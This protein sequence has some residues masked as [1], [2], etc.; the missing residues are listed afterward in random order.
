M[1]DISDRLG[2]P[3]VIIPT[4]SM[5]ILGA[6]ATETPEGTKLVLAS[7]F[8]PSFV[9]YGVQFNEGGKPTVTLERV[10]SNEAS[11]D[12]DGG[13]PKT[14][15][16]ETAPG[17]SAPRAGTGQMSRDRKTLFYLQNGGREIGKYDVTNGT[18]LP[19]LG[20]LQE[21]GEDFLMTSPG[22]LTTIEDYTDC[23]LREYSFTDGLN[24]QLSRELPLGASMIYGLCRVNGKTLVVAPSASNASEEPGVY[25]V[26]YNS[27]SQ[28]SLLVKV[29]E[30]SLL[31]PTTRALTPVHQDHKLKGFF[32]ATY[33]FR[34]NT[35]SLGT[36][37]QLLYVPVREEKT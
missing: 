18:V 36:P 24:L 5:P 35:A 25:E 22:F 30:F 11:A 23:V 1:A 28:S 26:D 15:W 20:Q 7:Y 31:P 29:P 33:D 14:L 10:I 8:E 37:S 27:G 4:F 12:Y 17:H 16:A 21:R 9:I 34:R 3:Q 2:E 19:P 6:K 13:V 32:A